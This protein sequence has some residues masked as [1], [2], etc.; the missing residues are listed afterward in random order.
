M[1]TGGCLQRATPEHALCPAHGEEPGEQGEAGQVLRQHQ[2]PPHC[3][4]G[5]SRHSG[6]HTGNRTSLAF[7]RKKL[8]NSYILLSYYG[9]YGI[10]PYEILRNV[11]EISLSPNFFSN[12]LLN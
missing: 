2:V 11:G 4:R 9:E 7:N 10:L 12:F 5:H 6:R 8:R 3:G 1:M